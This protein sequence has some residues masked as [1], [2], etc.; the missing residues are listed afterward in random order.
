MD[1]RTTELIAI[2]ASITANCY[3]CIKYH[4]NKA[5]ECGVDAKE[6]AAAVAVGKMVRKGVMGE[7]DKL[8]STVFKD[9]AEPDDT[10]G[11]ES[12]CSE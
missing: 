12:A 1:D 7:M 3:P 11:C 8:V 4:V 10:P 2:G 6:I 9:A 5:K